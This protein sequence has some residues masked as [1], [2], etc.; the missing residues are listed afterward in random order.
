MQNQNQSQG[1]QVQEYVRPSRIEIEPI[2]SAVGLVALV[3]AVNAWWV[4]PAVQPA[5]PT[6]QT[7]NLSS[8]S[9]N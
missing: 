3:L 2:L 4:P 6:L 5:T 8:S 7:A 1:R 9:G